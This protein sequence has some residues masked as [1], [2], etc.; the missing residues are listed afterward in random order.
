M[1]S[2]KLTQILSVPSF[3]EVLH[4]LARP[5]CALLLFRWL[6]FS[7]VFGGDIEDF[8]YLVDGVGAR[9][10]N[11]RGTGSGL[12]IPER[13]DDFPRT[14]IGDR[15]LS[16]CTGLTS[17]Y[18]EGNAPTIQGIDWDNPGGLFNNCPAA[19]VYIHPETLGWQSTW[20]GRPSA[21]WMPAPSYGDRVKSTGLC[22]RYPAASS[23][24]DDPDQATTQRRFIL[25]HA[26]DHAFY[27]G[28]L[29][30]RGQSP[31]C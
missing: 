29:D 28:I 2:M 15:A 7:S 27:R 25:S 18:F 12:A 24:T 17:V 4:C 9:V 31:G 6:S 30:Q 11:Y 22:I 23:Q 19:I 20:K 1:V 14:S 26:A 8:D 16:R 10:I 13:L 3:Y 5:G 21:L